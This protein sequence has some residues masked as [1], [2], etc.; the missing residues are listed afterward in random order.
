MAPLVEPKSLHKLSLAAVSLAVDSACSDIFLE[1][2]CYGNEVREATKTVLPRT[3]YSVH[4]HS[5]ITS[6]PL[7]RL[8]RIVTTLDPILDEDGCSLYNLD[9]YAYYTIDVEKG[10]Q[11][12]L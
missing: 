11:L 7:S 2:G 6:R 4:L 10:A 5:I 3:I 1:H 9:T 12:L 8:Y